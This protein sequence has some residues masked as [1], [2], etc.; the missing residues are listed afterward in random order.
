[1]DPFKTK[2]AI[3]GFALIASANADGQELPNIEDLVKERITNM[4]EPV[5]MD[6]A[7]INA[8]E[9]R[10]GEHIREAM[11]E[12]QNNLELRKL[13]SDSEEPWWAKEGICEGDCP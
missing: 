3:W 6:D 12:N 7:I 1:M 9:M 11:L 5:S 4:V 10:F 2:L 8:E 13:S